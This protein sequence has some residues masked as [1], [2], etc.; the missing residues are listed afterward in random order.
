M[1]VLIV[2][3]IPSLDAFENLVQPGGIIL[4]NSSIIPQKV[5]RSDVK[6]IYVPASDLAKQEGLL[7]AANIIILC[8]YIIVSKIV[9]IETLKAIIPISLKKKKYIDIN[10]KMVQRAL[11]FYEENKESL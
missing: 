1:D 8:V 6:A 9:D 10:M 7:A 3:N 4:V 11:Q 5:K 2:M